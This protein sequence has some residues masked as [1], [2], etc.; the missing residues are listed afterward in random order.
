MSEF[1]NLF[2]AVD[3]ALADNFNI[4]I[5]NDGM[6][7]EADAFEAFVAELKPIGVKLTQIAEDRIFMEFI[8]CSRFLIV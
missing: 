5:D 1:K 2:I 3:D 4:D 6:I 8:N 7:S